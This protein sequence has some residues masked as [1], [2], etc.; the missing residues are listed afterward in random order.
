M[1]Q[2]ES[3]VFLLKNSMIFDV[4]IFFFRFIIGLGLAG[5]V[6]G[7]GRDCEGVVEGGG[8]D[9]VSEGV[10]SDIVGLDT[11]FRQPTMC[12]G[13]VLSAFSIKGGGSV[14][15][16]EGG[17]GGGPRD[18]SMQLSDCGG[19]G[20]EG[21][22]VITRQP[23]LFVT[24]EVTFGGGEGDGSASLQAGGGV[25]VEPGGGVEV[26]D[27]SANIPAGG[28]VR[29]GPGR[30]VGAASF[31]GRLHLVFV[32]L[33]SFSCSRCILL[34]LLALDGC[35]GSEVLA[36]LSGCVVFSSSLAST[37]NSS[38]G[39]TNVQLSTCVGCL[40]VFILLSGGRLLGDDVLRPVEAVGG[41]SFSSVIVGFCVGKVGV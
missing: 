38:L 32:R 6:E 18:I 15:E 33:E 29:V 4:F 41:F 34:L 23:I 30:G 9:V 7:V 10:G 22:F 28:G 25:R 13:G 16:G 31:S 14:G 3:I 26:G 27:V 12:R 36:I 21:L 8:G 39:C 11:L 37:A 17:G 1:V 5:V 19:R 24:V 20:R 40:V 2:F 35:V